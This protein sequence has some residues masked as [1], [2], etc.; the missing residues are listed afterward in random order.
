MSSGGSSLSQGEGLRRGV[1]LHIPFCASKCGY[2]NFYSCVA[3][4]SVQE[5][6][7]SAL[8]RAVETAGTGEE[9]ATVYIG[10]GTPSVLPEDAFDRIF[11]SLRHAFDCS[12]A[13][14][15]TVEC[16]PDSAD[17]NF[18]QRLK[19]AGVNRISMGCQSFV[20]EEL[21]QLG[22]R[23]TAADARRAFRAARNAGFDNISLDLMLAIPLQTKESL[24]RSLQAVAELSPEH[25]SAYLLKIE[26][27]TPFSRRPILP[28][29]DLA[30]DLYLLASEFLSCKGYE[31]YE[32]S[33]FARKGFRAKH[34]SAYWQGRE[35]YAFGPGS[36]G[37]LCGERFFWEADLSRF[38]SGTP[39]RIIEERLSAED[40]RREKRILSL[41]TSDGVKVD[42]LTYE[43]AA[44][45]NGLI[46]SGLVKA[47]DGRFSL[48]PS[49]FLVSNEILSHL[50]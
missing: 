20:E 46:P 18:F 33:N 44:Y 27:G 26:E 3:A 36:Y 42:G 35:Y 32:V 8:C 21:Q 43:Q 5:T 50:F 9:I 19:H 14:E 12:Q 22:R 6:Y 39:R 4:R 49:G 2:C 24:T 30:A 34:N 23:H 45:L 11:C 13:E 25:L 15:I 48:T 37:Y 31:P 40:I 28:D 47:S 7:V 17:E 1:Y 38:L 29:D 10:G 16:N 41:R